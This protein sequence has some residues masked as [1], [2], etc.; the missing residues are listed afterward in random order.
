MTPIFSVSP[1]LPFGKQCILQTPRRLTCRWPDASLVMAI[2]SSLICDLSR[3]HRC[4]FEINNWFSTDFFGWNWCRHQQPYSA[5]VNRLLGYDVLQ[6]RSAR[7][8]LLSIYFRDIFMRSVGRSGL[9]VIRTYSARQGS[10]LCP[11]ISCAPPSSNHG[12]WIVDS[13][14]GLDYGLLMGFC[15]TCV[16]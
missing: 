8:I 12:L 14:R 13:R 6:I 1:P 2:A 15:R 11:A 3:S 5:D 10:A 16:S 9:L 4:I 7:G